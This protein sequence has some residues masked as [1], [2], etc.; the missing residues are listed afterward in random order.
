MA[1]PSSRMLTEAPPKLGRRLVRVL[2]AL[3]SPM[4]CQLLGT[5]LK[6]SRRQFGVVACAVSRE[7]VTRCLSHGNVDVA[8]INAD[9][10]DGPLTGLE[11]LPQLNASY[12]GTS[13]VL[14][15]DRWQDDL[16]V[17]AFHA[18][19]KGV[20]CRSETKL[21]LLWRCIHA[22]H[23]GQV[24]A[25]SKQLHLLLNTLRS[26]VR[27]RTASS[28]R[29]NLLAD[30]ESEVASLVAEG[31]PNKDIALK[32]GIREH[33]VSNYLFRIYE[34]LGVSGR[35]ELVLYIMKERDNR[36]PS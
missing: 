26:T 31:L 33:T 12:P 2:I 28:P 1:S 30:R 24:W 19:A 35:V 27:I 4:D 17:R 36:P 7:D 34:K 25:N 10:E 23:Q 14:L 3:A 5:A 18:G 29:M 9:L 8:L 13:V 20:F 21:D 6:R 15:F 11:L 16:I 32:L 22:V